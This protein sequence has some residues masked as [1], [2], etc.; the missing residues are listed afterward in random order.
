VSVTLFAT[1]NLPPDVEISSADVFVNVTQLEKHAPN[2]MML[3]ILIELGNGEVKIRVQQPSIWFLCLFVF[4][5]VFV[6]FDAL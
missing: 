3:N 1:F 4:F 5:L 2:Q 6:S